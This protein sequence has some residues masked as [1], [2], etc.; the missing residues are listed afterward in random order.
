M[1]FL[2]TRNSGFSSPAFR[3]TKVVLGS[4][5]AYVYY[6]QAATGRGIMEN[7]NRC[8]I[9]CHCHGAGYRML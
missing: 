8:R 6:L 5:T 2:L 9:G 1:V 4:A 3:M 7:E